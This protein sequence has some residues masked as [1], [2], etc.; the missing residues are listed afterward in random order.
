MLEEIKELKER[1][2][3]IQLL[4]EEFLKRS[5]EVFF[6]GIGQFFKSTNKL[7]SVAWTQYT[8]YFNDGSDCVFSANICYLEIN[9]EDQDEIDTLTPNIILKN[10]VWDRTLS[11]YK[12]RVEEPNPNFDKELSDV[13]ESISEFLKCF[14]GDFY[15]QQF[16]DHIKITIT[17]TGIETEEYEHE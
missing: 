17:S 9:G 1:R 11:L 7:Q 5:R 12:D 16:G 4:K 2:L 13:V 15:K 8:P 3:E 14:D 10:G 6:K